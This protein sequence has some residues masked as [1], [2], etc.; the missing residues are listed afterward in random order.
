M[1]IDAESIYTVRGG[2][3][4]GAVAR[5]KYGDNRKSRF[6]CGGDRRMQWAG[7]DEAGN[8]AD[9]EFGKAHGRHNSKPYGRRKCFPCLS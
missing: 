3:R 9:S 4:A 2:V 7:A 1:V 5:N 6:L 8:R